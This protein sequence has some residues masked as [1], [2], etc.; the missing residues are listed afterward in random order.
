MSD[1]KYIKFTGLNATNT[2]TDV[3]V[4]AFGFKKVAYATSSPFQ[5]LSFRTVIA[6]DEAQDIVFFV[7]GPDGTDFTTGGA[8]GYEEADYIKYAN[9]I[10]DFMLESTKQTEV[11]RVVKAGGAPAGG[12]I[13][14]QDN[15]ILPTVGR[16][17]QI[18]IA[19]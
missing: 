11:V 4:P 14:G 16:I 10:V 15:D 3:L 5:T 12:S 18:T 1:Y 8:T 2:Q 7:E 19:P 17:R 6:D 9:A 13:S